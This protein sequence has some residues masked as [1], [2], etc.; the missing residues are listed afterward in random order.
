[1]ARS[2]DDAWLKAEGE[3][4]QSRQSKRVASVREEQAGAE[5]GRTRAGG[6]CVERRNG[7]IACG[8]GGEDI[9]H[10]GCD[11]SSTGKRGAYGDHIARHRAKRVSADQ[12]DCEA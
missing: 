7:D 6:G 10:R 11:A 3:M 4:L 9:G 1:M 5:D 12:G 2:L 8:M